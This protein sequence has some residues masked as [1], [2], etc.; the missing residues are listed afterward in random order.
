MHANFDRH[1]LNALCHPD[2]RYLGDDI[3]IHQFAHTMH[4]QGVTLVFP[5]FNSE[6]SNLYSAAKSG[7]YWGSGHYAMTNYIDYF[8]EGVQRYFDANYNDR[9]ALT[10]REKLKTQDP[11]F[12]TFLDK[13][14]GNNYWREKKPFNHV[15]QGNQP[16]PTTSVE[17]LIVVK[18][19]INLMFSRNIVK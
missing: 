14:L 15:I 19:C 7:K 11:E 9:N 2:D 3:T 4:L 18:Q 6:L 17:A 16:I 5:A 1:S 8:A 10:T 12:F 13:Y